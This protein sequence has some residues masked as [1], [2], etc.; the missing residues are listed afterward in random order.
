MFNLY[1]SVIKS[2]TGRYEFQ[3]LYSFIIVCNVHSNVLNYFEVISLKY[4]QFELFATGE[5]GA[6]T[7]R[8]HRSC[9]EVRF[10]E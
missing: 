2:S 10:I 1:F 5:S 8:D 9:T 4:F 3:K 6:A 7:N